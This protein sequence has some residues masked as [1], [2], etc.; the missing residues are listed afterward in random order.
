[1]TISIRYA[2]H[3]GLAALFVAAALLG[4]LSGVLFA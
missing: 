4:P 1:M 2:R 3:A